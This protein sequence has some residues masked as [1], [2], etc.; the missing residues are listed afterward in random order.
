MA[1]K[2]HVN[3]S[4]ARN[5]QRACVRI[6]LTRVNDEHVDLAVSE[7][8]TSK[9]ILSVKGS[10]TTDTMLNSDGHG[11]GNVTCKETMEKGRV[12]LF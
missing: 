4:F 8:L 5:C 6:G 10:I 1:C 12:L 3:C 7:S 11:H 9:A 2:A